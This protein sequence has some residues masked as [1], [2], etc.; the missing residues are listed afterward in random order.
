MVAASVLVNGRCATELGGEYNADGV[1]ISE[2]LPM[3]AW[4]M[5]KAA[6]VR[7]LSSTQG[8]IDRGQYLMHTSYTQSGTIRHPAMGAWVLR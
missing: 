2:Y 3:L 8:A 6:V 7:S 4:Q 5:D 1:M